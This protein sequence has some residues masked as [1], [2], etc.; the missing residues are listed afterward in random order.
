MLEVEQW[1]IQNNQSFFMKELNNLNQK[2][3]PEAT[4]EQ[5]I[6][7]VKKA[8]LELLNVLEANQAKSEL[9]E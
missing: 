1:I 8:E 3:E 6:E 7:N 5:T 2:Q 9:S 4:L